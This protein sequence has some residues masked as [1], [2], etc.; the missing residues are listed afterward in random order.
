MIPAAPRSDFFALYSVE[1]QKLDRALDRD[2][3][4][5]IGKWSASGALLSGGA[6][7]GLVRECTNSIPVRAQVAL[8]LLLRTLAAHGTPL[9]DEVSSDCREIVFGLLNDQRS[10]FIARLEE[11]PPFRMKNAG[12]ARQSALKDIDEVIDLENRRIQ[13]E[14][15]LIVAA[16]KRPT[17]DSSPSLN[18]H[19]PVGVVQTGSGSYAVSNQTID[20]SAAQKLN[21]ALAKLEADLSSESG[22]EVDD[23]RELVAD[24]KTELQKERPNPSKVKA[25][26][27]GIGSTIEFMPKIR[28][29]YDAVKWAASLVGINLP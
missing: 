8:N 4:T 28:P 2:I 17:A 25:L 9:T 29:A 13:G 14:I 5:S 7:L 3:N 24:A 20:A 19:G 1:K 16:S 21:E 23:V 27:Q 10:Q 11:T 18:F 15:N 22:T 26:F 6:M 12:S